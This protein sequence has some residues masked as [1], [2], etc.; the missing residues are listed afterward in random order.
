MA[1][2]P[3][4]KN[5]QKRLSR[6]SYSHRIS[7]PLPV[8]QQENAFF[9]PLPGVGLIGMWCGAWGISSSQ[10]VRLCPLSADVSDVFCRT[11]QKLG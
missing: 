11:K 3:H 7:A 6:Y 8:R 9:T 2:H 4:Q 5:I 10:L 1:K